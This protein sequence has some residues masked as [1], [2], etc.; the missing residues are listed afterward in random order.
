MHCDCTI[1]GSYSDYILLWLDL[2]AP[3]PRVR[4]TYLPNIPTL[5]GPH[6]C[7]RISPRKHKEKTIL[8]VINSKWREIKL[9]LRKLP[10]SLKIPEWKSTV[11]GANRQD[12]FGVLGGNWTEFQAPY[13]LWAFNN[14]LLKLKR[15]VLV[16]KWSF[17]IS[18]IS[19]VRME[20]RPSRV[21]KARNYPSG[22]Q[23]QQRIFPL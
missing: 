16:E 2:N 11:P 9:L 23:E 6:T 14:S 1:I 4:F 15:L 21:P 7:L 12:A 17:T 20:T 5:S 22:D 19:F 18:A 3:Y 13:W 10:L 8:K